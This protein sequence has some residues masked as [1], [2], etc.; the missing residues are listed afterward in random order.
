[1]QLHLGPLRNN[2]TR[3]MATVGA[4]AGCDSMGDKPQAEGLS[5]FLDGLDTPIVTYTGTS[6]TFGNPG[7]KLILEVDFDGAWTIDDFL[8]SVELNFV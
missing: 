7:D 8:A 1:M 6:A 5:R 4:D 2:S 3:L